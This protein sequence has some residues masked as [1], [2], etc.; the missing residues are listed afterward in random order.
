LFFLLEVPKVS[1]NSKGGHGYGGR[2]R[3]GGRGHTSKAHKK[4][5]GK[6]M[7]ARTPAITALQEAQKGGK[8]FKPVREHLEKSLNEN[9]KAI[10]ATDK[11]FKD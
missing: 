10:I 7:A 6:L 8:S 11:A 5:I 2:S 3:S 4:I 9:T 1:Y